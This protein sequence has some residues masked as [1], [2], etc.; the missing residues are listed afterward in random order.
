MIGS[1]PGTVYAP[2]IPLSNVQEPYAY[3]IVLQYSRNCVQHPLCR[4]FNAGRYQLGSQYPEIKF[5]RQWVDPLSVTNYIEGKNDSRTGAVSFSYY[6]FPRILMVRAN[7]RR[8]C[9]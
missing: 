9:I 3:K 4:A 8:A 1:T 2:Q 6:P 5:E 7:G